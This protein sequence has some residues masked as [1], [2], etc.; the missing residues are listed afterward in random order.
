M[1][2]HPT[3]HKDQTSL[4]LMWEEQ[5]GTKMLST[6]NCTLIR[7]PQGKVLK[8]LTAK[9]MS[10]LKDGKAGAY[11][12]LMHIKNTQHASMIPDALQKEFFE[13]LL[14]LPHHGPAPDPPQSNLVRPSS[15]GQEDMS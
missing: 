11:P 13:T 2:D 6:T 4:S 15:Q 10:R 5:Q 8:F 3:E 12:T 14:D 7:M 1:D 9:E